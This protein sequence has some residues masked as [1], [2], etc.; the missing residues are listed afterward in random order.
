MAKAWR[1]SIR[2]LKQLPAHTINYPGKATLKGSHKT[3]R[4]HPPRSLRQIDWRRKRDSALISDP[5]TVQL[6]IPTEV[7]NPSP[8]AALRYNHKAVSRFEVEPAWPQYSRQRV[9]KSDCP[10]PKAVNHFEDGRCARN[11][12]IFSRFSGLGSRRPR[13]QSPRVLLFTARIRQH[14]TAV[15]LRSNRRFLIRSPIC[16]GSAGYWSDFHK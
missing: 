13:S 3:L 16:L 5:K 8:Q 14:S 12:M 11:Q 15:I 10:Q 9:P 6:S 1:P 2:A 4:N 7:P